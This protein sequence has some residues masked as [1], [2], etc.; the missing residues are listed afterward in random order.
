MAPLDTFANTSAEVHALGHGLF[1]GLFTRPWR[2]RPGEMLPENDDV[3]S[4]PH[5]YRGAFV[6][7]ALLQVVLWVLGVGWFSMG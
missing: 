3:Q 1:W 2:V 7:G 6:I 5:Y 4:E